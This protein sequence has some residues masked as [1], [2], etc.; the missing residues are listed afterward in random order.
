MS[1]YY[2]MQ[3]C[4]Q[5]ARAGGQTLLDW[6]GRFG[7]RE[8]GPS[9]LVTEADCASQE[10]IRQILMAAF[11]DSVSS[12]KRPTTFEHVGRILLDR[13]S[14][15]RHDK[16]RAP[17][18][19]LRGLGGAGAPG[20]AGGRCGVRSACTTNAFRRLA[21]SGAYL[22]GQPIRSLSTSR[23]LSQA[24]VAA[25]FSAKVKAGSVGNRSVRSPHS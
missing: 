5:A 11:P 19:A 10:V 21:A 18:A 2:H 15:G 20:H 16:L 9:D 22:N 1:E 7:V 25:S 14:A 4:E 3:L 17:L 12:A 24:L 13:R 6:I 8:K 23:N